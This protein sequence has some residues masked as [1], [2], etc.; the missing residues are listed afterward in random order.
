MSYKKAPSLKN[1]AEKIT[2]RILGERI[3]VER[4]EHGGDIILT[5]GS[6]PVQKGMI[7]A[8]GDE[9]DKVGVGEVVLYPNDTPQFPITINKKKY[10]IIFQ[11]EA[12][13]VF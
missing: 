5:P 10:I 4:I 1:G 11:M 2:G 12:L 13:Y 6:L 7:V 9:V 8:I 3:L